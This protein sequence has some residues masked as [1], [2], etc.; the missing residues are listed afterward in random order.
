MFHRAGSF[1]DGALL[2][3]NLGDDSDTTG[4][5]YGPVRG[6]SYGDAGSSG[7]GGVGW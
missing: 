3:V 2:A 6:A 7:A 5:F 1:R 4:A